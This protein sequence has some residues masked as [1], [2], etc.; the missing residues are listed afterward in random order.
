LIIGGF[1]ELA[2]A[3]LARDRN[4]VVTARDPVTVVDSLARKVGTA[5]A[6]KLDVTERFASDIIPYFA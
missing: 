3:V 2:R 6:S 4:A 5:L 1:S